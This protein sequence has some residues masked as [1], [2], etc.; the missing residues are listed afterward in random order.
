MLGEHVLRLVGERL[1]LRSF[2]EVTVEDDAQLDFS[3]FRVERDAGVL[4]DDQDGFGHRKTAYTLMA[5][6]GTGLFD[7]DSLVDEIA[8]ASRDS[9]RPSCYAP[10]R[11]GSAEVAA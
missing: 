2:V 7:D 4:L 9:A 8:F 6:L 11:R 10:V 3:D 5:T 1:G